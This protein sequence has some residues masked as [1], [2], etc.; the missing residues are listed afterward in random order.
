MWA[1]VITEDKV[2][3]CSFSSADQLRAFV[4]LRSR[5]IKVSNGC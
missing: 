3:R 2:V 5:D 1:N 4:K